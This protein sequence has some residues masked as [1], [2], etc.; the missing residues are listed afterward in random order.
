MKKQLLTLPIIL[1]LGTLANES[2]AQVLKTK[3]Q[4]TVRNDLGNIVQGAVVTLYQTQ[5]DYENNEN[6]VLSEETD[7]NGKITF[8]NLKPVSYFMDVRKGD[9]NNDGRGVQTTKLIPNKKNLIAT[10]IE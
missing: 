3:L 2:Y 4:V 7:E 8:K 10:I 9:M 1:F 5:A 6:A